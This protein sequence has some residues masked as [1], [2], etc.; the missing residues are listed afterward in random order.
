MVQHAINPTMSWDLGPKVPTA[1]LHSGACLKDVSR[2][3]AEK[4]DGEVCF[5]SM[6]RKYD[7]E[8]GHN[9][10][11]QMVFRIR[12]A[13]YSPNRYF[14]A[15]GSMCDFKRSFSLAEP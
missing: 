7:P 5:T 10:P 15:A 6:F 1:E 11:G 3:A 2:S 13:E 9:S 12:T 14:F 4:S 8:H